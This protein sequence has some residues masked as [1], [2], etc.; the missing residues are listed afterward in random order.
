MYWVFGANLVPNACLRKTTHQILCCR[1]NKNLTGTARYA[2]VNTHLGVGEWCYF[3]T[4]FRLVTVNHISKMQVYFLLL[5]LTQFF[6][7]YWQSKAEEMIWN[8]LVMCLCIS[9][10]EGLVYSA[11]FSFHSMFYALPDDV[12][13]LLVNESSFL[14]FFPLILIQFTQFLCFSLPWQG[15]KAGTKKQKYDKI[16]EKKVSTPIE[17]WSLMPSLDK[18]ISFNK[19]GWVTNLTDVGISSACTQACSSSVCGP[20]LIFGF[21]LSHFYGMFD[22]YYKPF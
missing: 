3:V 11:S 7:F 5:L 21:P 9:W 18:L 14:A 22:K 8:P 17:V 20:G 12:W 6:L 10:G 4:H 15:L 2:S 16:S 19:F 13:L 1:E